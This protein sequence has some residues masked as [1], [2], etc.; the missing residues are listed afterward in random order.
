MLVRTSTDEIKR[1]YAGSVFGMSWFFIMPILFLIFYAVVYLVVYKVKP[2]DMSPLD[3]LRF[4]YIGLMAYLGFSEAMTSG[5]GALVSNKSI[6][7]NT[8]FPAELIALRTVLVTQTT[9][10][11]GFV[12]AII[13]CLIGGHWSAWLLLIPVIMAMQIA[14][15]IGLAW[16]LAPIYVVFRDLGQ[17]LSFVSLAILI[18]SPIAY[19]ASSLVGIQAILLYVNPLYF[20][21]ASYQAII[22]DASHPPLW[23]FLMGLLA[24]VVTFTLGFVFF[25]LTS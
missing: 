14:F 17:L 23:P 21:L 2:T 24:A 7:L 15:L 8:V 16:V 10:V 3:Y 5:A 19:R 20:Y 6:L 11:I 13:W 25:G 18:I 1:K 22:F 9:F 12:L 4:I